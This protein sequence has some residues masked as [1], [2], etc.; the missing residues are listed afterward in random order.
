MRTNTDYSY[1]GAAL[2][3][4]WPQ[5][6]AGDREPFP[7]AARIAKLVKNS[8]DSSEGVTRGGGAA[9][10]A[11]AIL[12]AWRAFHSGDFTG[13]I[14]RGSALGAAGVMVANKA[15][16]M[17]TL[18]LEKRERKCLEI[19]RQAIERGEVATR[20]L[21]GYANAHY[22]LALVLGR[23]S[24][25]IS[26]L[27]A[28]AAGYGGRIRDLLEK[29]LELEP[30]HAEAHIALGLFHAELVKTLG[31]LAARLTYGA[32]GQA[33][34]EHFRR[35][36]RLFPRSAAAYV[37]Y[38]HGLRLLDADAHRAQIEELRAHAAAHQPMDRAEELDLERLR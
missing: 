38:A 1:T 37:E 11:A 33:A 22:A 27:E 15:A 35:A 12:A 14:E 6:H 28:L 10:F 17:Q 26:I 24:Q 18:Y 19:L 3:K 32:S 13:A 23:Y 29:T 21:P 36:V 9:E 5:L 30:R 4:Q 16:A 31:S 2:K 7:S 25:R 20:Q 8:A 34:I